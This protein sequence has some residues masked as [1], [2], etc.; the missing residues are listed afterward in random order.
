MFNK[1]RGALV[2]LL[3]ILAL[4]AWAGPGVLTDEEMDG[5]YAQGVVINLDIHL[6]FPGGNSFSLPSFDLSLPV[7]GGA[8]PGGTAFPGSGINQMAGNALQGATG[9]TINAATAAISMTVNVVMANNSIIVGNIIQ[10][11]NS[12]PT[13]VLFSFMAF[14]P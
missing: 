14:S 6:G 11:S 3:S 2:F 9:L 12:F 7:R 13:N 1:M 10:S 4:P 8:N 5:I